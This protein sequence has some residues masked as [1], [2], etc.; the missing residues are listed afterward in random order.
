MPAGGKY[1][2]GVQ[3]VEARLKGRTVSGWSN[4]GR[5]DSALRPRPCPG[6]KNTYRSPGFTFVELEKKVAFETSGCKRLHGIMTRIKSARM[7]GNTMESFG[8][9]SRHP[10]DSQ[11]IKVAPVSERLKSLK[12]KPIC[13]SD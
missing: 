2:P 6:S 9:T 12:G 3:D 4:K 5:Q 13:D 10:G 8:D 7:R 1:C 11:P